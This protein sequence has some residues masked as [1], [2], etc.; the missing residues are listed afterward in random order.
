MIST[1]RTG[2]MPKNLKRQANIANNLI[3]R[4]ADNGFQVHLLKATFQISLIPC[5]EDSEGR[6]EEVR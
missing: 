2:N 1:E 5:S 3:H 6:V 4:E